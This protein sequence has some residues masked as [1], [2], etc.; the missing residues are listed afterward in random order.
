MVTGAAFLSAREQLACHTGMLASMC[1][2]ARGDPFVNRVE[3]KSIHHK[4]YLHPH[5][6]HCFC[7]QRQEEATTV[8]RDF[9]EWVPQI[10]TLTQ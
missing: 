7:T 3:N 10:Y 9:P 6:S 2:S 8:L 1:S 4:G 5:A